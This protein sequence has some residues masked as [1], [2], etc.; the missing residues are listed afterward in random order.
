MHLAPAD[1]K[2]VTNLRK[3]MD[4]DHEEGPSYAVENDGHSYVSIRMTDGDE[5][6]LP[7]GTASLQVSDAINALGT[8]WIAVDAATLD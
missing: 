1:E 8:L 2:V 6:H 4:W 7:C 5:V 3:V